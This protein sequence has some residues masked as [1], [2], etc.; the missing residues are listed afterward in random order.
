MAGIEF[1]KWRRT[2]E[3]SQQV[4]ANK[5]DCNVS[6]ICRWEKGEIS[7]GSYIYDKIIIF[8]NTVGDD[9]HLK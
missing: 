6:T 1:R 9:S 5:C 3:I 2:N 8:M 7:I 4:V